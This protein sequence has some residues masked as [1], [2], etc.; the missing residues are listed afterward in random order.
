MAVGLGVIGR[1]VVMTIGGQ[2]IL[3]NQTKGLSVNNEMLDVSDEN[4]SGWTEALAIPGA[5]TIELPFSGVIKN[6]ELLRAMMTAGSQMYAVSLTYT[7]G[8]TVTG[9][10]FMQSY[11]ET[12][13]A[14]GL[15][16]FDVSCTFSGAPTFTAGV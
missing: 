13:E 14:N 9:D 10:A 15:Y 3:G 11:S 6:L 4:S 5:K 12:G 2:N 8:S 16:T 1:E 7:D